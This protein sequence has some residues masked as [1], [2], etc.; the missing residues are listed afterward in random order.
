M[1]SLLLFFPRNFLPAIVH[2]E[3]RNIVTLPTGEEVEFDPTTQE[4]VAGVFSESPVDLNP[5]RTARKFPGIEYHGQGVLV[6]ANA[7]GSDPR[8]GTPN[9]TRDAITT[10]VTCSTPM[11][12]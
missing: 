2:S 10:V 12:T 3:T 9:S 6:R 1:N 4:V 8:I 11:P 5:D 7:R